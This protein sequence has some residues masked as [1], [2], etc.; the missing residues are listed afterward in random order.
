METSENFEDK[1]ETRIEQEVAEH[2]KAIH[3]HYED[4]FNSSNPS[5]PNSFRV[6]LDIIAQARSYWLSDFS[7]T[8]DVSVCSDDVEM[9][10]V[11]F[12][13]VN[14]D[15]LTILNDNRVILEDFKFTEILKI[16]QDSKYVVDKVTKIP[17]S[18]V[19]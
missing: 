6:K 7:C 12:L 13:G 14:S 4:T 17:I 16:A 3:E 5:R 18:L 10:G 19:L 11:R 8:Y 1:T 2:S 15:G 9:E